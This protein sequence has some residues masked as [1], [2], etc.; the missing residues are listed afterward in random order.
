MAGVIS[1]QPAD[2]QLK[3]RG[4]NKSFLNSAQKL[5]EI[6]PEADFNKLFEQYKNHLASF[7]VKLTEETKKETTISEKAEIT[8][9]PVAVSTA[10]SFPAPTQSAPIPVLKPVEATQSIF[11]APKPTEPVKPLF[12]ITK[13]M[14]ELPKASEPAKSIFELPKAS[15]PVIS[16]FDIKPAESIKPIIE[17]P[18]TTEI[19]KPIF[20][21]PKAS[22]PSKPTFEMPKSTD[23]AKPM[24]EL[25]KFE[26]KPTESVEQIK[27]I[28]TVMSSEP[29]KSIETIK[30]ANPFS[31]G[32]TESPAPA[33]KPF[34]FGLTTESSSNAPTFKPF[35]F[36]TANSSESASVAVPFSFGAGNTGGT[37]SGLPAF[38]FGSN[39]STFGGFS[40]PIPSE[41]QSGGEDGGNDEIPAEEAESFTLT[42]TQLKTG[43]GEENETCQHE[44]R[45]KIF[46]MDR[47][48][49]N[50]WIDLGVGTFKINRYNNEA[51][52]SRVLCR[53]EGS[54][55]VI[56]NTL[57]NVPGMDVT[58]IEGKKEVA[59]LA[60][61][62]DG[63]PTKYLIR[64]KTLEQAAS[65]K[66]ALQSEIEYVK[67]GK[68]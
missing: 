67:S 41:N 32:S 16:V 7:S 20:E 65:L 45:C 12:G 8:A 19:P 39:P 31:F 14:F 34:S 62:P 5:I 52:K 33:F 66:T 22:E 9:V 54:G 26:S 30:P 17:I 4:L 38:S 40:V 47:N 64:V 59:L 36:G 58:T 29:V 24:F 13:P 35:S 18:K 63:K 1:A 2:F 57:V 28:E 60:I 55:K 50:G 25:P 23:S 46:A 43:A 27:P 44:E 61:G 42:R 3:M 53:A 37:A 15:E 21:L 10:F 6:S 56:L 49:G 48:G 51:G 68:S 11:E